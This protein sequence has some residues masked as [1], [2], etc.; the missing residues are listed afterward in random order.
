MSVVGDE[1]SGKGSWDQPW[2]THTQQLPCLLSPPA[3]KQAA[4]CTSLA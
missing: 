1:Q 4:H 3:P 2:Q